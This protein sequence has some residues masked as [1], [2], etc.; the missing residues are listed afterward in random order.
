MRARHDIRRLVAAGLVVVA[1]TACRRKPQGEPPPS[2]HHTLHGAKVVP[3]EGDDDG[4]WTMPAKDLQATRFSRLEQI[5]P[6]NVGQLQ[7]KW[8]F[9]TKIYRGHEEAP[10]V[11]GDTLYLV[12][13]FPNKLFA[14]DLTSSQGPS[15]AP[16][17][18]YDP[19]V[20]HAAQGVACCDV[21][22]RGAV[23]HEG[24]IIY[25]T[26]DAHTV[27]VDAKDGHEVWRTKL[28]EIS[29][30]ESMTMAPLLVKGKVLVGN[31]GGEFGVRGW[32][33]ALDANDG[34]QLWRAYSTGPDGDCLIGPNFKPFYAHDRGVDLG[35]HTW[36]PEKWKIGGGTVWG[37]VSYDPELDLIFYGTAN[38][39]PWNPDQRAGDNKWTAGLFARKPDTGDAAWFFQYSPHDLHDYDGVNESIVVDLELNGVRR[40]VLLHAERNGYLMV[41]DRGTGEVLSAIPFDHIT[42][43]RGFDPKEGK[44]I[45]VE[46]KS[47]TTNKVSH[48][49]CPAS[50][51]AKDW[52]PMAWS[53]KTGLLYIPH[54]HLCQEEEGVEANYIA[55]TPYVGANVKMYAGPGGYRGVYRAWD[56]IAGKSKWEIHESF[57]VWT[58]TVVTSANVAFYGTLDGWFKAVDAVTGKILWTYKL[59]SGTVGQPITFKGPD[60]KQ[61]V[62]ITSGPGGWAG[63]VVAA[64]LDTRDHTGALGFIG[65]VTDLPKA[66]KAGG[67]LYVFGLP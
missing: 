33:T 4:Q 10:L 34:K 15:K 60:G 41:I 56:P 53:P 52:Q 2:E 24:K 44:F 55:G 43:T 61:Y 39:G 28:G 46:E 35:V 42:S 22:N 1:A 62:A 32:L 45:P 30:G 21:V 63:A 26:L 37:W 54:Q 59:D 23:F 66:T 36:P 7:L 14:F 19:K 48:D 31:S 18:V 8:S 3:L 38:P 57:P 13:P 67:S 25:N 64:G 17:W 5:T 11:V 51:G 12:T 27:A 65:A 9:D 6:A 29:K 47:P 20:D 40:K 50:P 16:K 49:I 58:G